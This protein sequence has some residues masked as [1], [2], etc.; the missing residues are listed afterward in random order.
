MPNMKDKFP[1]V[2]RDLSDGIDGEPGSPL[3]EQCKSFA[4]AGFNAAIDMLSTPEEQSSPRIEVLQY[5]GYNGEYAQKRELLWRCDIVGVSGERE[6][7]GKWMDDAR[8]HPDKKYALQ[9]AA[10]WHKRTG[11]KVLDWGRCSDQD[12]EAETM[13]VPSH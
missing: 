5:L 12:E 10:T 8:G 13:Y 7:G 4:Q 6:R 11:W 2:W 1:Q 3:Y 9:D